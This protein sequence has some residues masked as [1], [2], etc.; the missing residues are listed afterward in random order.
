[1]LCSPPSGGVGGALAADLPKEGTYDVTSCS[2]G[3]GS[4]IAFSK[5]HTASSFE[6]TGTARSNPP[7]G[8]F[9]MVTF[10]CVGMGSS[11]EGRNTGMNLCEVI[12]K[13]GDKYLVRNTVEGPKSVQE[14][15]AGTGKYE[16]MVRTG[17]TESVGQFPTIK[18]GTFQSC[19]R[20][21]GTDKLK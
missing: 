8:A 3:V 21:T 7:G 19:N 2:S 12:D 13:D 14:T 16:G 10:R 20:G 15:L 17:T 1:M 11:I 9:D 18:P 5:T 6:V 4:V